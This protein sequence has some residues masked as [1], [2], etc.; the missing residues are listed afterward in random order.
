MIKHREFLVF[1]K[2]CI[3]GKLEKKHELFDTWDEAVDFVDEIVNSNY[4]FDIR[5]EENSLYQE[6]I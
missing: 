6:E 4:I 2:D 3:L 1:W 5:I